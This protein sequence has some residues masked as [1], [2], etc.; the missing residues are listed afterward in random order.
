MTGTRD[1]RCD[2]M[3]RR[4]VLR[5]GALT[6]LG[7]GLADFMRSTASGGMV[8][9]RAKSC[10]LLWLD[11]GPSHL[12]TFDL[13]PQAPSEV[14]G[15]FRPIATNVDGIQIS[16]LLPETAK[17]T[18]KL[19]II[20]SMTSP[21][22]EHG[23]ANQFLLTGY[24]PSPVLQYPSFGSVLAHLG[25]AAPTMP[26]Y[27]AIPEAG[28]AGA[29]F[30]GASREPFA[31]KGD[32]AKPDFRVLDLDFFPG[33]DA[34]RLNRRKNFRQ[35]LD[36]MQ[37]D[38]ETANLATDHA[39]EQA[40]RLVTSPEAKQAFDLAQESEKIRSRYGGRTFGQS[41]LLARRL[42]ERGVPF[43]TVNSTGWDTHADLLLRLKE[44]YTGAN[45]GVGLIPTFDLGFAALID[46]LQQR[47]LL[48]ETLVVA[49]GEFGRTPKL[50]PQGG[51]DHWPRVFS[52]VLAGG[53]VRGGQVIGASDRVGENPA[54][55]PVTPKDLAFSIYTLL[56]I[57]PQRELQT[58]DGRPVAINQG[59]QMI[60]GLI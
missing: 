54:L 11:G 6:G 19:A 48:A 5:V 30:L 18:N 45:P 53:G 33:V 43:V 27:V 40:Y 42:I 52:V 9:R 36:R 32:P 37:A 20:R 58:S 46:D 7:L 57:D 39:F 10:I 38:F 17:I 26:P 22:G 50:N 12:E 60:K 1:R 25:S 55:Q 16:E 15:P 51:R 49:M 31:V 34:E 24:E 47:G 44:G 23:L 59:G 2:G 41:C 4:D 3:H 28:W 13:K 56:G 21:L 14:R 8:A 29:G 35:Q